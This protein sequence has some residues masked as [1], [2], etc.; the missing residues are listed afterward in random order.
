M[1][2]NATTYSFRL[3]LFEIETKDYKGVAYLQDY[4]PIR[5]DDVLP[6][7]ARDHYDSEALYEEALANR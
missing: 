7:F 3:N 2:D 4:K 6:A 5:P 1:N